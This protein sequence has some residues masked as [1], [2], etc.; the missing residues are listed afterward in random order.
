MLALP[1]LPCD[2]ASGKIRFEITDPESVDFDEPQTARTK[3]LHPNPILQIPSSKCPCPNSKWVCIRPL[4]AE[5]VL[6]IRMKDSSYEG[7]VVLW[8]GD[9]RGVMEDVQIGRHGPRF[10]G[11]FVRW[12]AMFMK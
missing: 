5:N 9:R 3:C 10:L 7:Q 8:Q 4:E 1:D 6:R 11:S 12:G 2:P